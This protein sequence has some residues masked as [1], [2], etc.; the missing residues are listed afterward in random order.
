MKRSELYALVWEKPVIRLAKE[1]GVS[2]VGL[3]KACRRHDIPIPPRGH[4]TKLQ[5]AKASPQTPLPA[6]DQD[7]DVQLTIPTPRE[8]ARKEKSRAQVK[9]VER[10][11]KELPPTS[12]EISAG[13]ETQH[14]L[15]KAT[16]A[17]IQRIPKIIKRYERTNWLDRGADFESPPYAQH[18]RYSFQV[19]NG[20]VVTAS[21][22]KMDWVMRFFNSLFAALAQSDARAKRLDVD[23]P[24]GGAKEASLSI[25]LAGES[26]A[27]TMS[28]GY[29]KYELDA[30]EF[31]L[32]K[33]KESWAKSW[34][35]VPSESF[36]LCVRGTEYSLSKEWRGTTPQLEKQFPVI[37]ATIL[38][39]LRSQPTVREDRIREEDIR[40][41]A[42]KRAEE[43]RQIKQAKA[44]QLK[45]AFGIAVEYD[46]VTQ[47]NRFLETLETELSR[48]EEPYQERARVWVSVVRREL[49]ESNPYL[50]ALG[51]C[52]SPEY[53]WSKWP[54]LWWPS[55]PD[56]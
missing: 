34:R 30:E 19:P 17:Y 53:S 22:E 45:K 1:L 33:I 26:L 47:L 49:A 46:R 7:E 3:A 13:L 31:Q 29:R 8:V 54:P 5:F 43:V 28:E 36:T 27:I 20:L 37:V 12:F 21:L 2:D 56:E 51:S 50:D 48:F 44:E 11:A 32:A 39:L 52:L 40:R 41:T 10:I 4:W 35:Y 23:P 6:Q 9:V 18:G 14:P 15:V 16:N 42:A 38:A 55:P 24:R 25:E